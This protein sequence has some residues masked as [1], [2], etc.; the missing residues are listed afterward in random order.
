MLTNRG[1]VLFGRIGL[2]ATGKSLVNLATRY[3]V[4]TSTMVARSSRLLIR[5]ATITLVAAMECYRIRIGRPTA[6]E[7]SQQYVTRVRRS[8]TTIDDNDGL[9][10]AQW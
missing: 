8:A 9:F 3:N 4:R 7:V 1:E 6:C 2:L 5:I 10:Y